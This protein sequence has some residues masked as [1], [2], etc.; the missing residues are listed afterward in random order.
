MII[1]V[2]QPYIRKW[3]D[4]LHNLA[5]VELFLLLLSAWVLQQNYSAGLDGLTDILLSLVLI[6]LVLSVAVG[7]IIRCVFF[8]RRALWR[9]KRKVMA[10]FM[11]REED[12]PGS[13]GGSG[14]SQRGSVESS[15]NPSD[16]HEGSQL[17]LTRVSSAT[18][19]NVHVPVSPPPHE[20]YNEG[21]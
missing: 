10:K 11:E 13:G 5:Q 14:E 17:P 9:Y 4:R 8:F 15:S 7:F 2:R 3:D 12:E 16:E 19:S 6:L 20:T 21:Q 1:L 18:S